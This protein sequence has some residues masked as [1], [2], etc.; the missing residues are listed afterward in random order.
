MGGLC[1]PRSTC[2]LIMHEHKSTNCCGLHPMHSCCYAPCCAVA[3]GVHEGYTPQKGLDTNTTHTH[4]WAAA[5][6]WKHTAM[7]NLLGRRPAADAFKGP[8]PTSVRTEGCTTQMH[9]AHCRQHFRGTHTML[10]G[11]VAVLQATP[12]PPKPKHT[13]PTRQGV[14]A[15]AGDQRLPLC[16]SNCELTGARRHPPSTTQCCSAPCGRWHG[17]GGHSCDS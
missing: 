13:I 11:H 10:H 16:P 15:D 1:S 12:T 5:E 2:P 9:P 7:A 6:E 14:T 3:Q 17:A 4:S 8:M